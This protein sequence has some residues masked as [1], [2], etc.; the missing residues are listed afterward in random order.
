MQH[1]NFLAAFSASAFCKV[2]LILRCCGSGVAE[3]GANGGAWAL[4]ANPAYH[5]AAHRANFWALQF[6]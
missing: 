6:A 5:L 3:R 1:A 4:A 2:Q